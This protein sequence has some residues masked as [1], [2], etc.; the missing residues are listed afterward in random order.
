M[1]RIKLS[2]LN[3]YDVGN[4]IQIYGAIYRSRDRIYLIPL[5]DEDPGDV[6]HLEVVV[7]FL[8]PPEELA[9]RAPGALLLQMDADDMAK[10]L[11]QTD[12]LDVQGPGKAILRKSQRQVDAIV[13]WKVFERDGYRC[14]YCG[15][16]GLPLTVDHVDLWEQG[17]ATME[18]NLVSA[19]R[20]CN[21]TRGSLGYL[22]W[23]AS[24][25]Y[26]SRSIHLGPL[27]KYDNQAL[28][29]KLPH[30]QTLRVQRRS[31]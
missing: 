30:L 12:V 26:V 13:S 4:E 5:P 27:V 7:D 20:N 11:N 17:G 29:N 21:K 19:C 16:G 22:E 8:S 23:L 3:I 18:E 31:R 28:I 9:A 1:R 25:E 10:F 15:R 2:D 24:A 14:R 6:E